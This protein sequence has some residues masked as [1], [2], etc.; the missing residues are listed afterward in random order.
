MPKGLSFKLILISLLFSFSVLIA[1]PKIPVKVDFSI[2]KLDSYLGGY[3]IKIPQKDGE[4]VIDLTDFKRSSET[5]ESQK[6]TFKLKDE[7]IENK[8]EVLESIYEI[9]EKRLNLAG[10]NDY[11][12]GIENEDTL[13]VVV[14][15]HQTFERISN[16][17]LGNGKVTFKSIIEADTWKPEDYVNF[18]T[19]MGRWQD[20]GITDADLKGFLYS[21]DPTTGAP[22]LQLSFTPEGRQRFYEIAAENIGLPIAVYVN[23][24][25]YPLLMPVISDNILDNT[26]LDPSVGGGFDQQSI[27]DLNMQMKNPLPYDLSY[28][29]NTTL[30]PLLGSDFLYSYAT[31]FGIGLI[32]VFIFF[33][34]KFKLFGILYNLSLLISLSLFFSLVKIFSISVSPSLVVGTVLITVIMSSFGYDIFSRMKKELKED[35]PFSFVIQKV[36]EKEKDIVSIPSIFIF[37]FSVVSSL[38]LKGEARVLSSI[39]STGM[40]SVIYF[41]A[42]VFPTLVESFGGY[43]K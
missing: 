3:E 10:I 22:S 9:S 30:E 19:D 29:E 18:Y 32:L 2:L 39:I 36:F 35:K 11:R 1:L 26:S 23:G 8:Q 34:F 4:R 20:T 38:F 43:K 15:S 13:V 6:L 37:S 42:I 16:L 31:S 25:E 28:I 41:Y 33:V 17:I 5:G 24:Y 14:P 7:N 40:L 12:I 27:S 21:I